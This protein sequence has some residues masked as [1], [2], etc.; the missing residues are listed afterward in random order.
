MRGGGIAF[1]SPDSLTV[2]QAEL[3]IKKYMNDHPEQLNAAQGD[4][5]ASAMYGAYHCAVHGK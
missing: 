4:I 5:A 2:L 1:C 3:I